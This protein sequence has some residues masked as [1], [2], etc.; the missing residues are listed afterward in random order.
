M[1]T[2][3]EAAEAVRLFASHGYDGPLRVA[4][5]TDETE[6]AFVLPDGVLASLLDATALVIQL[7]EALHRK[8]W[9]SVIA[10][11]G[12]KTPSP[13]TSRPLACGCCHR[14]KVTASESADRLTGHEHL[15]V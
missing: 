13:S 7:Q 8:V 9:T 4:R 11:P 14:S 15:T 5:V 10:P 12:L 1:L 2:D 6:R 3:P